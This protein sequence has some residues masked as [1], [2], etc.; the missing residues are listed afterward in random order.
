MRAPG[1]RRSQPLVVTTSMREDES[2][3]GFVARLAECNFYDGPRSI[4]D[5]LQLRTGKRILSILDVASDRDQ[6]HALECLAAMPERSLL[7]A[8]WYEVQSVAEVHYGVQG[9]PIPLDALMT[10]HAQVCPLCLA[11]GGYAKQEWDY[12][13]VTVCSAHSSTLIAECAACGEELSQLRPRLTHCGECGADLRLAR[14]EAASVEEVRLTEYIAAVA[15]YRLAGGVSQ[16]VDGASSLFGLVHTMSF[17]GLDIVQGHWRAR[18]MRSLGMR[19]RRAAALRVARALDGNV[20]DGYRLHLQL[21]DLV[22]HRRPHLPS[23]LWSAPLFEFVS[24]GNFLSV[25]ARQLLGLGRFG[26]ERPRAIE[27]LGKQP[28]MVTT[29]AEARAFV[30]CKDE[31]WTWLERRYPLQPPRKGFGYDLDLLLTA[32]AHARDLA[33][34]EDSDTR[35]GIHGLTERLVKSNVLRRVP[36]HSRLIDLRETGQVLDALKLKAAAHHGDNCGLVPLRYIATSL[37]ERIDLYAS[38]IAHALRSALVRFAWTGPYTV[39][40]FWVLPADVA[41]IRLGVVA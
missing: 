17:D 27:V 16:I 11:E 32:R 1:A 22:A 38:F 26:A 18:R 30:G 10:E 6:L 12:S 21:L 31:I 29:A 28:K 3:S 23:H 25:E 34:F 40:D 8:H 7:G 36:G 4:F 9:V 41:K 13:A 2:L 39:N 14:V 35:L 20:V 24:Q 37:S 33:L 15:P 5:L 19:A